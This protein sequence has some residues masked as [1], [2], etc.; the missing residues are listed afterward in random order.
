MAGR[1]RPDRAA[2][3]RA[4]REGVEHGHEPLTAFTVVGT[5]NEL[6]MKYGIDS[7]DAL[8]MASPMCLSVTA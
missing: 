8:V 6:S 3:P 1:P 7:G 5:G 4:G 2:A